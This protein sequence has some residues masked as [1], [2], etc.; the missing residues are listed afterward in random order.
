MRVRI[1]IA[2]ICTLLAGNLAA[3]TMVPVSQSRTI[4]ADARL[5]RLPVII[6]SYKEGDED[7]MRGLEVGADHYL[8]KSS[9]HD[10]QL[11]NAVR[12]LIGAAE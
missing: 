3:Q 10:D 1:P 2:G 7:R 4:R 12:S 5:A 6:V 9:F 8:A 11:A